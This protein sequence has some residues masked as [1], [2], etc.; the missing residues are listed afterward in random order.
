ML[1]ILIIEEFEQYL[2]K[3]IPITE[4]IA[5]EYYMLEEK[6][7]EYINGLVCLSQKYN[8]PFASDIALIKAQIYTYI[9]EKQNSS[10]YER[11]QK[12]NIF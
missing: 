7:A 4:S 5:T 6:T 2:N 8:M 10:K 1:S 12:N 3:M 9:P 11:K